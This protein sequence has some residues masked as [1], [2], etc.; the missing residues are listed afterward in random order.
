MIQS[1]D[2]SMKQH[3]KCVIYFSRTRDF[4]LFILFYYKFSVFA[5][6]IEELTKRKKTVK[7]LVFKTDFFSIVQEKNI[8]NFSIESSLF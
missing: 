5:R 3:E 8:P 7:S 2:D 6:H 4:L 1:T